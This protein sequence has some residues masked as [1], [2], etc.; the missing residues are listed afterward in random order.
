MSSAKLLVLAGAFDHVKGGE[1]FSPTQ[2]ALVLSFP[3]NFFC[4][5]PL[6]SNAGELSTKVPAGDGGSAANA[7]QLIAMTAKHPASIFTVFLGFPWEICRITGRDDS[8]LTAS[9]KAA[10]LPP[11]GYS[12]RCNFAPGSSPEHHFALDSYK[13]CCISP[14]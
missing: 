10:Y 11:A 2:L 6:S 4:K 3:A 1:I 8:M 9:E 7:V 12:R 14:G 5:R 13:R